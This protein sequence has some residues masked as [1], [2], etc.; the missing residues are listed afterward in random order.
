MAAGVSSE[1]S[2]GPQPE[3]F[4]GL[5]SPPSVLAMGKPFVLRAWAEGQLASLGEEGRASVAASGP[6]ALLGLCAF[7]S[8]DFN[9]VD[10]TLAAAS[11]LVGEGPWTD[12]I[13][14]RVVL[15]RSLAAVVA[16][17]R[18]QTD[19]AEQA[20]SAAFEPEGGPDV[21]KAR[22]VAYSMRAALASEGEPERALSDV[23]RARELSADVGNE[24]LAA[25]A[26][27][28]EGW[29]LSELGQLDDSVAILQR[30]TRELPGELERAVAM[31]RL[32]EVQLR[33]GDRASAREIIESAHETFVEADARYWAARSA[34]L[35][36][37]IDRDRGGRWLRRARELSLPDPAY[38]RLFLPDGS[39]VINLASQPVVLRDGV[40]VAFLTRHAEAA[41]R[42]LAVSASKGMSSTELNDIFWPGVPLER[43]RPRL[44]TL[45]WQARNSLG[46]DAWRV[47]RRGDHIFLD[48]DGV[49]LNGST[50]A[51][52]IAAEFPKRRSSR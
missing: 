34:L 36:G 25:V 46:A 14:T 20:F 41:V 33:I 23:Q 45:L 1:G 6:Y 24:R 51:S 11:K 35:A 2:G 29:A 38:D 48:T 7:W 12:E 40:P 21:E 26:T 10:E 17:L 52:A 18:G 4:E 8:G 31:V 43:Q 47:Q 15:Q 9:A 13:A 28:G 16:S 42:L 49:E 3:G 50:T 30:A 37:A 39:L 5:T 19:L 27:I 22:I 44:R 32:A